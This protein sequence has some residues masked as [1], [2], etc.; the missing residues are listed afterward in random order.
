MINE[1]HGRKVMDEDFEEIASLRKQ[2]E[3][4]KYMLAEKDKQVYE[5]QDELVKA[6]RILEDKIYESEKLK[7]QAIVETDKCNDLKQQCISLERD[8]QDLEAQI[9]AI[10]AEIDKL[11][12][13][14]NQLSST[15]S[16]Q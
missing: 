2:A 14:K 8:V 4:L 12:Q 3:D 10:R 7:D 15:I 1:D 13:L 5:S 9:A 6:K 16:S 11:L